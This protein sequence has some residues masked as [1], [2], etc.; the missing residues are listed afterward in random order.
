VVFVVN[1]KTKRF[2]PSSPFTLT[3][4]QI[5]WLKTKDNASQVLRWL[6]ELA[7]TSENFEHSYDMLK[8]IEEKITVLTRD[9]E[10]FYSTHASKHEMAKFHN[11]LEELKEKRKKWLVKLL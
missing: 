6:L 8:L 11:Q 3:I 5:E 4:Q 9:I 10:G 7:M 1:T 2:Y